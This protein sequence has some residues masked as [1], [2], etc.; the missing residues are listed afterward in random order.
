M[1]EKDKIGI[2]AFFEIHSKIHFQQ[3]Y[4]VFYIDD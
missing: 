1:A 3:E 4:T 2:P